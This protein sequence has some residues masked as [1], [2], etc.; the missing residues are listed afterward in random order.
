MAQVRMISDLK[1]AI[2][3]RLRDESLPCEIEI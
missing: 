1:S 2:E 3:T